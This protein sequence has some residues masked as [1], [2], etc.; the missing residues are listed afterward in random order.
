MKKKLFGFILAFAFILTGAVCLT[1]CSDRDVKYY[2]TQNVPEHCEIVFQGQAWDDKGYY[3][4]DGEKCDFWVNIEEGYECT[5]FKLTVGTTELTPTE[6]Q[7]VSD[8]NYV[9]QYTYSYTPTAD[10]TIKVT[11]NF[12][13]ISKQLTLSKTEWYDENDA[14]NSLLFIRFDQNAFGLPT[15]ETVYSTFVNTRLNNFTRTMAYGD[16]LS[17]D[18]YY[19]GETFLGNP[20]VAD[21][22]YGNCTSTFYHEN[23]EIG[24]HFT[25][26]QGYKNSTVTFSNYTANSIFSVIVNSAGHQYQ[27]DIESDKLNI[28]RSQADRQTV[29]ITL[30]DHANIDAEILSGLRLK[31]NGEDQNVNF[32]QLT[33]GVYTF[34]LKNPWEYS[35]SW[36]G[37]SYEIDLNFYE[38]DYF[39][40]VVE[41]IQ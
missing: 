33:N 5:D 40:G 25:Y 3:V 26:T 1:A 4:L 19:K 10:F 8:T 9:I 22:L 34:E 12:A 21:G 30:K 41:I 14:N 17:F 35:D 31:I 29:I 23:G 11:G 13:K 20:S 7:S 2:Y 36:S 16:S 28:I 24:Y 6:T 32:A 39:D 37:L 27:D 38:F 18:V 15:N